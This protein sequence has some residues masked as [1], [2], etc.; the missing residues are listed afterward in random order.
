MSKS[1]NAI[2][3]YDIKKYKDNLTFNEDLDDTSYYSE[4]NSSIDSYMPR[5]T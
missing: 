4:S 3:K 2:P 1:A 5:E